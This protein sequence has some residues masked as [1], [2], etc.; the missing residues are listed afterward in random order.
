M[1]SIGAKPLLH[2]LVSSGLRV[3]RDETTI[4]A[5][6]SITQEIRDGIA[7]SKFLVAFYQA[8]IL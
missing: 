4:D 3:F 1:T 6:T 5:G 7:G 8:P 2:A